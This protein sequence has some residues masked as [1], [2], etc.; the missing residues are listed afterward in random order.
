[1]FNVVQGRIGEKELSSA[2]R[3]V[4]DSKATQTVVDALTGDVTEHSTLIQ[5]NAQQI[6]LRALAGGLG[7]ANLLKDS[8]FEFG[9]TDKWTQSGTGWSFTAT[10]RTGGVC[11]SVA[12]AVGVAKHVR[13]SVAFNNI[14]TKLMA[15]CYIKT[16]S[17]VDGPT[18]PFVMLYVDVTDGGGAHHYLNSGHAGAGT[19][20]WTRYTL[21]IDP[22]GWASPTIASVLVHGYVWDVTGTAYFDDFQLEEGSEVTAWKPNANEIKNSSVTITEDRVRIAT[23]LFELLLGTE[24]GARFEYGISS[25]NPYQSGYNA[26][27]A[28]R[29]QILVD[30]I[31]FFESGGGVGEEISITTGNM[32]ITVGTGKD[33]STWQAAFNAIPLIVNHTVYVD[34]YNGSYN[35]SP[36]LRNK[37]GSGTIRVREY[38]G[39]SVSVKNIQVYGVSA[40]VSFEDF[41]I[42]ENGFSI[43][44]CRDVR[45]QGITMTASTAQSGVAATCS[46]VKVRESTI[47]NHGNGILAIDRSVVAL[48]Y[49]DGTGND[50]GIYAT[51]SYIDADSSN[52][53]TGTTPREISGGLVSAGS[54][55]IN[56][57]VLR[58]AAN[59]GNGTV[60]NV[61]GSDYVSSVASNANGLQINL[62]NLPSDAAMDVT[63]KIV[64]ST[65][66]DSAEPFMY[67]RSLTTS[68]FILG[69][70]ATPTGAAI[71][72]NTI[73]AGTV[74]IS[75]SW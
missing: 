45:I 4:I 71:P 41:S 53:I 52:T 48:A 6:L 49:V 2:L 15:S 19:K 30:R 44:N 35:E 42:T 23:A 34:V 64:S 37:L 59:S 33:Y 36:T 16:D 1:L 75:I 17:I 73:A 62:Q 22:S 66:L 9:G 12:G 29:M 38:T 13:Q 5:Q 10:G 21:E 39:Q 63:W 8:S 60:T 14:P 46:C 47:S 54:N 43:T 69:I 56:H 51:E 50:V 65:G 3:N 40:S 20:G 7:G 27:N 11:A 61:L 57:I 55:S 25:G 18:N 72:W 28:L 32:T 26:A 70:K 58:V 67:Q 68:A 24:G 74:Q 31:K